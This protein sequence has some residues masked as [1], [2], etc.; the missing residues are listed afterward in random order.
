[1]A[2]K[3]FLQFTT[4]SSRDIPAESGTGEAGDV[5][6]INRPLRFGQRAW[7]TFTAITGS[8]PVTALG[9]S[10]AV[11]TLNNS[12]GRHETD[13]R[14]LE[15]GGYFQADH[16]WAGSMHETAPLDNIFDRGD[17]RIFDRFGPH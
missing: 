2:I 4:K 11:A 6:V 15:I 13:A 14:H 16:A 12:E 5:S 1:M 17:E 10:S 3:R 9:E 8:T 7:A